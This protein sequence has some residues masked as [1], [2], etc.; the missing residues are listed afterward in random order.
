CEIQ[1]QTIRPGRTIELVEAVMRIADRSVVR[2]RAWFLSTP[3]TT[4]VAGG[5][6][7]RLAAPEELAPWALS[8]TW[9]GGYIAPLDFRAVTQPKPGRATALVTSSPDLVAGQ[10]ASPLA[11]YLSRVD[12]AHGTA[13]RQSATERMYS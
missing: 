1:V 11:T 6:A 9:P 2:A 8:S 12:T 3:D 4:A 5:P 7:D 10:T 13:V